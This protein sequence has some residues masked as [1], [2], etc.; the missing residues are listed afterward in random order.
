VG[1]DRWPENAA[2][3]VAEF[4]ATTSGT[5]SQWHF[6]ATVTGFPRHEIGREVAPQHG[7]GA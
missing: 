7:G 5:S 1:F 4:I 6:A 2:E 3:F